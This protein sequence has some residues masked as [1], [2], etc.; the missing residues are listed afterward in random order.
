M[1]RSHVR[2]TDF[3][4]RYGSEEMAVLM[5]NAKKDVAFQVAEQLRTALDRARFRSSDETVHVTASCRLC[6]SDGTDT[7]ESVFK[8]ADTALYEAKTQGRKPH[9]RR[10]RQ[11]TTVRLSSFTCSLLTARSPVK[12]RNPGIKIALTHRYA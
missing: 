4:A 12:C 9:R 7:P 11:P 1:L 8:R 2:E 10:L 5:A 3:V 6:E